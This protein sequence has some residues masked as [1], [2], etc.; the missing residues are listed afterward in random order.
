MLLVEAAVRPDGTTSRE[1]LRR[2]VDAGVVL[3]ALV[4]TAQA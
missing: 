3:A 4:P 2:D 1:D